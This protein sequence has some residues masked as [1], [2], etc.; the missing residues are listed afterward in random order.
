MLWD[1][2]VQSASTPAAMAAYSVFAVAL[3]FYMIRTVGSR[4]SREERQTRI[5]PSEEFEV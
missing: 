1:Q 2:W 4:L 5:V 3:I